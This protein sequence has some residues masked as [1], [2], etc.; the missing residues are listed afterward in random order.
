MNTNASPIILCSTSRLSQS[1]K[2]AHGKE[3]IAN[4]EKAWFSLQAMTL[5]Q[6]LEDLTESALLAGGIDYSLAPRMV[7]DGLQERILWERVI[8]SSM[9]DEVMAS[10]FDVSGMANAAMDANR[11]LLAWDVV[12]PSGDMTVETRQFMGWRES[13]RK[14]CQQ[15]GWLEQARFFDWQIEHLARGAGQL[16]G[17]IFLCGFDRL[18]PQEQ[19]LF[20]A[21]SSR[22][23][24]IR[25]WS[26]T[27]SQPGE[28]SRTGLTDQDAECRAAA[29]WCRRHLSAD[30]DARL[31]LVVPELAALR[32]KLANLVDDLLHP[33]TIHPAAAES[34]RCYDF[35]LGPALAEQALVSVALKL[36]RLAVSCRRVT[37]E[38][39]SSL[40]LS[41]FW[42]ADLR[43]ADTRS[44]FDA[45]MRAS[46]PAT[47][48]LERLLNF[49]KKHQ[50]RGLSLEALA[51]HV[52]AMLQM[53]RAWPGR[54]L[55]SV[56]MTDW[57]ALLQAVQWPG[58]RSL[59]SHEFQ[60]RDAFTRLL[61]QQSRLDTLLGPIPATEALHHIEQSCREQVYQPQMEGEPRILIMGM[62]E[63]VAEPLTA[64]WVMGMNDHLWPPP[65]RPN[66]LLPAWSQRDAGAPNADS[67]IQAEFARNV[68]QRLLHSAPSVVFSYAQKDGERDLRPSPLLDG[69]A[70][71]AEIPVLASTLAKS[72]AQPAP[73]EWLLDHQAPPVMPGEKVGG[74]TGLLKAQAICPA[75][76]YYRYRLG[77]RVLEEPVEGLDAMGRGTLLHAAL[78]HFW[79]GRDSDQ[80]HALDAAGLEDAIRIAVEQGIRAYNSKQEEPLP[81]RFMA[82]EQQ[83][84]QRLLAVWLS[85]EKR[86]LP[87]TVALC[88]Q[89]E[90]VD[91]G[92]IT[93]DLAIDRVDRL[94]NGSLVVLDYKTG[95]LVSQKSWSDD[96]IT[97][98]QLPVYAAMALSGSEVAAVCFAKVR[99]DEQKFI[100][101]TASEDLLPDVTSLANARKLFDESRFPDWPALLQ[102]WQSSIAAIVDE[103]RNGEAA[104]RF[105]DENELRDCELKPLLR[106]PERKL[107]MERGKNEPE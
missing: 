67:R 9:A 33:G 55:P 75:W 107:Q 39:V 38:E 30:P 95:S 78:Q 28:A 1:L 14:I 46:L 84:L 71:M 2:Q 23:T 76:A 13:F 42:S 50:S 81:P 49:I 59:S 63:S 73:R 94:P 72:L 40:L 16:P 79:Q 43:E 47:L 99:I 96:R 11:L 83:R 77:A 93:V 8:E 87:F 24:A 64:M 105:G 22:G 31:G 91:L 52:E 97:E 56:W 80:L 70:E 98:P 89:R 41:P 60:A 4:G 19:R 15:N 66:P 53:A 104:T 103:I 3:Q 29:E 37:Q 6:W 90:Q 85:L 7:L 106:L 27:L 12:A 17:E 25:P 58:E 92:G 65:A 101:I 44:Q 26:N 69:I 82:L 61:D 48:S 10:L 32:E 100:G 5:A 88:E 62:L 86:R 35:S 45:L 34:P 20:H 74:G 51:G 68:H 21:L 54:Q 18:S 57:L 36:M 102:H